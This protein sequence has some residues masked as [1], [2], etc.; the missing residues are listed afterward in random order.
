MN[1]SMVYWLLVFLK[2]FFSLPGWGISEL[3]T[4]EP[5]VTA[6]CSK[7]TESSID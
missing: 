1:E 7:N 6:L 5:G 3:L 4:C 2:V